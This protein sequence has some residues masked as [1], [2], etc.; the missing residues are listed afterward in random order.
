MTFQHHGAFCTV[1]SH[2]ENVPDTDFTGEK[3]DKYPSRMCVSID[4]YEVCRWCYIAEADRIA[5]LEN[6]PPMI[7]TEENASGH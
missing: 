4:G 6:Q 7:R 1:P 2:Y 3:Y 5:I